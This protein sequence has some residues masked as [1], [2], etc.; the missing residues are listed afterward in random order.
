MENGGGVLYEGEM[1]SLMNV[2][3]VNPE[4]SED[5]ELGNSFPDHRTVQRNHPD[6]ESR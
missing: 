4:E 3:Y 6:P 5:H 2:V 1:M